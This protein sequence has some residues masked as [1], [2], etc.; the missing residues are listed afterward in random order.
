MNELL[1]LLVVA[2]CPL[3]MLAM[4]AGA[5]LSTKLP[6]RRDKDAGRPPSAEQPAAHS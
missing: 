1:P 3:G 2:L 5:W 6:S 4:G